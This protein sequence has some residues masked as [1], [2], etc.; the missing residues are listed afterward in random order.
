M[1]VDTAP[2]GLGERAQQVADPHAALSPAQVAAFFAH[3]AG[4]PRLIAMLQYGCGLHL[5]E[6]VRL[7]VA[8]L[9]LERRL[10]VVR[11][12]T[13]PD[14]VVP[15]PF[16][17]VEPLRELLAVRLRQHLAGRRGTGPLSATP[18]AA[19]RKPAAASG[20]WPW[21]HVFAGAEACADPDRE[22]SARLHLDPQL[23]QGIHHLAFRAAGVR[24]P[25][26]NQTLRECC[27]AHLL[28]RGCDPW[29]VRDLLGH[30]PIPAATAAERGRP[31][32]SAV[33][34]SPV[35]ALLSAVA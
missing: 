5:I 10:V 23:V 8:D 32:A 22:R 13:G 33:T 30:G 1:T 20:S 4:L 18:A 24:A 31:Q 26:C 25:V 6:A 15:V 16:A 19:T 29:A 7:R 27:A 21:Q 14:R 11:A 2:P 3:L 28:D 12:S 17:L 34:A 35:D 9:D